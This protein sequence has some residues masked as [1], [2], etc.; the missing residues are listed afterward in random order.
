VRVWT[1]PIAAAYG[2]ARMAL[3]LAS[4]ASWVRPRKHITVAERLRSFPLR[5]TPVA[6]PVEIRWNEHLV[7]FID[8]E[9][10]RDLAV[11]LGL[12]HAHLR[13]AQMELLRRIAQGRL[14][15]M[16]GARALTFDRALHAI[17][18]GRAVPAIIERF[19]TGSTVSSPGSITTSPRSRHRSNSACSA[20]G[21]IAGR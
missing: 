13:L 3:Q 11:A 7:P 2:A 15:E 4:A 17:D 1:S 12:V 19:A 18:I 21:R 20:L 10:D 14:A 9:S 8:A 6:A 16:L 5:H